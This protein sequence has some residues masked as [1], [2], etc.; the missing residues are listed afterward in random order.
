MRFLGKEAGWDRLH[1]LPPIRPKKGEQMVHGGF[2]GKEAG[3][4]IHF[5]RSTNSK[6]I[7]GVRRGD[8]HQDQAVD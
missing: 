3:A 2:L 4:L 6:R 8:G 1:A 5:H 7:A